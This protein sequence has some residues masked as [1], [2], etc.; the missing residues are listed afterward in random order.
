MHIPEAPWCSSNGAHSDDTCTIKAF[1]REGIFQSS[2]QDLQERPDGAA[3]STVASAER[4]CAINME[5]DV[6]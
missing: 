2:T 6:W 1:K 5:C 3:P 4:F